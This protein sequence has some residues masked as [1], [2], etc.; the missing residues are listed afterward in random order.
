LEKRQQ[1]A[2]CGQ[3][4]TAPQ[5]RAELEKLTERRVSLAYVYRLLHRH[6]WRKL[7]PR[8]RHPQA[9]TEAQEQFKRNFAAQVEAAVATRPPEDE[10]PVLIN[11]SRRRAFRSHL[12][13]QAMLGPAWHP[14]SI[15]TTNRA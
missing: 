12:S 7:M 13:S 11:G 4:L 1:A 10:R 14:A 3:I 15:P 8:P 9:T 5:L 2:L 6:G